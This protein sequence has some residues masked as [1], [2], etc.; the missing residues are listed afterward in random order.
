MSK[1]I[2]SLA[3]IF[4]CSTAAWFLLGAVTTERSSQQDYKLRE[5]VAQL[6]GNEQ[7]QAAPFF[8]YDHL[9][10]KRFP[11]KLPDSVYDRLIFDSALIPIQSSNI[12]VNVNLEHRKK[13]LI[14]YP[15][16]KSDFKAVY[17][18]QNKQNEEKDINMMYLFPSN[19]GIYDNFSLKVNGEE[20]TEILPDVGQVRHTIA[21]K[22]V[23]T[24]SIEIT[25]RTQGMDAWWYIFGSDVNL[26]NDFHLTMTTNFDDINFPDNSMSATTKTKIDDGWKL[27]W[28]YDNLLTGIQIGMEMPQKLN[29]GPFVSRLT[30]FAPV[31]LFLFLFLMFIITTVKK[32]DIHPMN[33]F[34]IACSFFSFHLLLA[35]L[36][37][38]INIHLA[39]LICSVVSL[40]LVISYMRLVIGIKFA[41]KEVGLAQFVYL[42]FFS[43][44]F[45]LEGFTALAVTICSI[46][47]LFVVM[48]TTAKLDWGA[49]FT[50]KS[51][52]KPAPLA[53]P[54]I[55]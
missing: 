2:G 35:Y 50:P 48:Q 15:T 5:S 45:F 30:F 17:S 16:Y 8:S 9:S 33:Y 14:W 24:K 41:L 18:V 42:I 19:D 46:G 34:F 44:A 43:Y 11:S 13:G 10:F 25:Y 55:K 1:Q 21:F 53:P 4:I 31:S 52:V 36:V 26:V 32:I 3:F 37:D 29:P 49:L 39:M 7:K 12:N 20:V 40:F 54:E 27:N 38:H 28:D 51:I 47:T 6:W 22:P 23:E